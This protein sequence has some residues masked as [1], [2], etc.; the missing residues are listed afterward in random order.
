MKMKSYNDWIIY[1]TLFLTVLIGFGF[2]GILNLKD[3][4]NNRRT[5]WEL[6]IFSFIVGTLILTMSD[7]VLKKE[8]REYFPRIGSSIVLA[9]IILL[10]GAGI[11]TILFTKQFYYIGASIT[12]FG[13]FFLSFSIAS[14]F[15]EFGKTIIDL[16]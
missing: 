4:I 8:Q 16:R 15:I 3:V 6:I 12:L 11:S 5:V 2:Y 9:G 7:K 10:I 13:I 1:P 14:L